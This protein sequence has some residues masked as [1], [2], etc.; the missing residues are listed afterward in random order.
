MSII[1]I[2]REA[3]I[4]AKLEENYG[5]EEALDETNSLRIFSGLAFTYNPFNRVTSPEKKQSPGPVNRFD[6]KKS[7]E[8]GNLEALIRPSGTLNTLPE[9]DPILEAAFGLK[10]NVTLSTTV[11]AS[12][13]PTTTGCTVASAGALAAGDAVLIYVTGED[14]PFVRVLTDV[15][16]NALTWAPALPSAPTSADAI[17][18]GI[19]YKLTTDLELSL[20]IAE[21]LSKNRELIGVGINALSLVFDANEDPKATASGP[22]ADQLYDSDVQNEPSDFVE[23]GVNPPSGMTGGL[24]VNDVRF[25]I[26]KLEAAIANGLALRNQEYGVNAATAVYRS[27]RREISLSIDCFEDHDT[28]IGDSEE[29]LYH[30]LMA[31]EEVSLLLQT[32][33]SEGNIVCLYAPRAEF[34]VPET[35]DAEEERSWTLA[36]IALETLDTMNDEL[37]LALL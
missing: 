35:D 11:S 10:T 30:L 32:G 18:G 26:K 29:S 23:I 27:A 1:P 24:Y 31:G 34:N 13:S 12:P 14:D 9:I 28:E 20:T 7:A 8:L 3:R 17:K 33:A 37:T 6:R 16:G 19:T 21:Y 25:E 5:V 36:G 2:G 22:A 15:T 4:Y